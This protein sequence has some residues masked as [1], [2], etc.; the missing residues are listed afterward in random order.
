MAG[1]WFMKDR[2]LLKVLKQKKNKLRDVVTQVEWKRFFFFL[3]FFKKKKIKKKYY[4]EL[5]SNEKKKIK[6][7]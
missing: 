1:K 7:L 5:F 3:N 2:D 6:V 4:E